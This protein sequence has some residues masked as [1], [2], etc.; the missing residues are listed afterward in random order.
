M[1]HHQ[2]LRR[3][4]GILLSLVMCL[5]LLPATAFAEGTATATA[6]FTIDATAALKLLNDAKTGTA[7]STWDSKTSTLTLKGVNFT[8]TNP[9]AVKLPDGAKIVLAEGT[10]NTIASAADN[11]DMSYGIYATDGLTIE[12]S[13]TLIVTAG[14][15]NLTA[16]ICATD[17]TIQ[18]AATVTA[19]GGSGI[20]G[21]QGSS[22]GI[23]GIKEVTI[24]GNANVTATG[25]KA[26]TS[27]GI[28][29]PGQGEGYWVY[30]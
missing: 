21:V 15:S 26:N 20:D 6:D 22:Y 16:G 19:A 14:T 29:V 1:K 10:T 8:T 12:G 9:T 7:D 3:G 28:R 27:Y 13:G 17:V 5:S 4:L 23:F 24:S 25:G 30:T 2:T 11:A 18:G